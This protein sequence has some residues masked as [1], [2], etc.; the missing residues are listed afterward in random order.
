VL[1]YFT[2]LVFLFLGA[3]ILVY[4]AGAIVLYFYDILFC[5][6]VYGVFDLFPDVAYKNIYLAMEKNEMFSQKKKK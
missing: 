2:F 3:K 1:I 5:F 4:F 6:G